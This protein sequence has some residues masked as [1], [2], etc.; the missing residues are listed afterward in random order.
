MNLRFDHLLPVISV[1]IG[2][3]QVNDGGSFRL[4]DVEIMM[5]KNVY[6]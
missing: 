5:M 3:P 2:D 1:N 6:F 4:F